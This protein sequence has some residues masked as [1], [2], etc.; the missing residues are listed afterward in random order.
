MNLKDRQSK[1]EQN[2]GN[3]TDITQKSNPQSEEQTLLSKVT[4]LSVALTA[5]TD[6]LEKEK[7]RSR[8]LDRTISKL[9]S[10]NS[11]LISKT[12]E[13]Q[14]LIAAL[15]T[16]I[17]EAQDINRSLQ[18]DNQALIQENGDL[19]YN[20]GVESR[21]EVDNLRN[22]IC[23]LHLEIADLNKQ[24]DHSNV[25]AVDR[26]YK[27]LKENDRIA[28]KTM[29][30]F[31]AF[32]K[33]KVKG[34][35]DEIES[36]NSII[37]SLYIRIRSEKNRLWFHRDLL[38]VYSLCALIT[39]PVIL[40]DIWELLTTAGLLLEEYYE[41][42]LCPCYSPYPGSMP[43]PYKPET[44]WVVRA[45]SV[46]AVL[47][48]TVLLIYACRRAYNQVRA[49]W[50]RLAARIT[51]SLIIIVSTVGPAVKEYLNWNTAVF[52]FIL[53]LLEIRLL[54]GLRNMFINNH[55]TDE[56]EH[57]K[58]QNDKTFYVT[59]H[60][61]AFLHEKAWDHKKDIKEN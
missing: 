21:K 25:A 55:K 54:F 27:E 61:Y 48:S 33:E 44:A 49:Q 39:N 38:F 22:E 13:Q 29:K 51:I 45:A 53:F 16:E 19:R 37:K 10:K 56:W 2:L 12:Q 6:A 35:V 30:D 47:A 8:A 40:L 57:I 5:T 43:Q 17:S 58:E 15:K 50:C 32:V 59:Y 41:W 34:Y 60:I 7:Q 28:K 52:L 46:I 20:H 26:A 9:S 24:V 18:K 1:E 23:R 31:Q 14:S 3:S 36:R 42:I 11:T 4:E